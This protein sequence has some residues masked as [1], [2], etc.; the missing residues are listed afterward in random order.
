[1]GTEARVTN[2]VAEEPREHHGRRHGRRAAGRKFSVE[3]GLWRRQRRGSHDPLRQVTGERPTSFVEIFDLLGFG[4]RVVV[5]GVLEMIVRDRQ[6]QAIA[7]DPE[8]RLGQLLGLMGDVPGFDAWSQGPA[9]DRLGQDHGRHPAM[10]GRRLVRRI[11][12]AVIVAT[13]TKLGEVVVCQMFHELAEARIWS[14]EVLADVRAAGNRIFLELAVDG[15]IHFLDERPVHVP[16]KEIVPLTAP[17]HLDHVPARPAES[18][19]KLLDDFPIATDRTVEALQVAV[20]DERQVVEAL[21]SRHVEGT[22]RL[23]FVRLAVAQERPDPRLRSVQQAA[24][25]E[26]AVIARLIDGADRPDPHRDRREFPEVGH[27]PWVRVGR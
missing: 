14:E 15:G 5:R 27:E 23:R 26:V 22:E 1:M 24:V 17:D 3:R 16:G 25:L 4:A 21:T 13:A 6:L 8:F 20:D 12:L 11:D 9:L 10:L 18:R 2:E 7:E 19:L